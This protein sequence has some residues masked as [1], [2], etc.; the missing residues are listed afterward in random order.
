[1][2][3][4]KMRKEAVLVHSTKGI[5]RSAVLITCYLMKLWECPPDYVINH[6][7]IMRP[8][9]IE[10]NEQ[11]KVVYQFHEIIA[12]SFEGFYKRLEYKFSDQ[13]QFLGNS[14]EASDPDLQ[15]VVE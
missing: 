4:A 15:L 3:R 11:E 1:M 8:V 5:G 6:L 10:S 7:R 14:A 12:P 2:D 9:S 13:T